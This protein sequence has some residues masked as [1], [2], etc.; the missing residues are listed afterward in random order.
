MG[1]DNWGDLPRPENHNPLAGDW[2][3]AGS[4]DTDPRR[5]G[6]RIPGGPRK[7]T[8]PTIG[9]VCGKVKIVGYVLG[10]RGGVKALEVVC[11]ECRSHKY[12]VDIHNFRRGRSTRCNICAKK[13]SGRWSKKYWGYADIIPNDAHRTRLLNRMSAAI[14]RC[15]NPKSRFFKHYGGR[16]ITVT[17][18]WLEDRRAMLRYLI[19]LTGWDDPALELDRIDNDKGYEPGNLR[20]CTRE[21]NMVNRR[22]IDE[23]QQENICLRSRIVRLE[24]QV[25]H[26]NICGA[27]NKS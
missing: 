11:L 24:Q 13:A 14:Q 27:D 23:L 12:T 9:E 19:T 2:G 25:H 16:G 17:E 7:R 5:L 10:P 18:G 22:T 8:L 20:F 1:I 6:I 21:K 3:H 4:S 15:T 26:P